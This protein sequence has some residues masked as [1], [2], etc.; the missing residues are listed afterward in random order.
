MRFSLPREG[1]R[2]VKIIWFPENC[3]VLRLLI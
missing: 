3:R 1:L 2:K